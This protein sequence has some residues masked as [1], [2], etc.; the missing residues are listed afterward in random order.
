MTKFDLYII[1]MFA[2]VLLH[3]HLNISLRLKSWFRLDMTKEIKL[4][5]SFALFSL[6]LSAIITLNPIIAMAVFVTVF[7]IEKLER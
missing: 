5:D 2:S 4:I 7:T 3:Q 1:A 6:C